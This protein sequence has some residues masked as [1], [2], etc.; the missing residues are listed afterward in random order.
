MT[1]QHADSTFR[2][3]ITERVT[4]DPSTPTSMCPASQSGTRRAV[5]PKTEPTRR[6]RLIGNGRRRPATILRPPAVAHGHTRALANV[7]A[8]SASRWRRIPPLLWVSIATPLHPPSSL[9]SVHARRAQRIREGIRKKYSS[10]FPSYLLFV[11]FCFCC[12]ASDSRSPTPVGRSAGRPVVSGAVAPPNFLSRPLTSSISVPRD[13]RRG[14][15]ERGGNGAAGRKGKFG[16]CVWG[17]AGS[18]PG[19]LPERAPGRATL[20]AR[21]ADRAAP[22]SAG[23][24]LSC[25]GGRH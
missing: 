20:P 2:R 14:G 1:L 11:L 13:E 5:V 15:N 22:R 19:L 4:V 25:G 6:A 10:A 23:V 8:V 21:N 9:L 24:G 7:A 3:I 16:K 12:L 17:K 18:G